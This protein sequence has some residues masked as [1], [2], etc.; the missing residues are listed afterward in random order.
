MAFLQTWLHQLATFFRDSVI[1]SPKIP[2]FSF[3]PVANSWMD[4]GATWIRTTVKFRPNDVII[5][6][7]P[8]SIQNWIIAVLL[9]ILILFFAGVIYRRALAS[10]ALLDDFVALIALYFVIRIEAQ[11]V[12]IGNVFGLSQ[13]ARSFLNNP[14]ASFVILMLLLLG[15]TFAG[16]GVRSARAFWRGLAEALLLAIFLFPA[17]AGKFIAA[18]ID[19]LAAFG[20]LIESNLSFSIVWGVLGLFL[21]V[22]RL[23]YADAQA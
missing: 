15:L 14:F 7:G 12:S 22:Q 5:S 3:V 19:A 10:S 23:Y 6:A 21:A 11:L 17:D 18:S 16:E 9:G 1:F 4:Q 8:V 13:A 2:P 20:A